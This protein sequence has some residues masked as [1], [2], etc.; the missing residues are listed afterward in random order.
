MFRPI[1]Q[2]ENLSKTVVNQIL[3]AINTGKLKPGDKLPSERKMVEIFNVSRTVIRDALK[4]LVGLGMIT[5]HHGIGTFVN[6]VDNQEG[7]CLLTSL[8]EIS[9]GTSEELLQVRE[10]L[11]SNAVVWCTYNATNEDVRQLGMIVEKSKKEV[12]ESK[13]ALF[14]AEFHLKIADAAGNSVLKRLMVNLMDLLGEN[15]L[16]A[17]RVPGRQHHSVAEHVQILDAI[18]ARNSDLARLYMLHHLENV[19]KEIRGANFAPK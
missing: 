18:K 4:T 1:K 15:R 12:D 14:D 17:L 13:L 3:E 9:K 7:F 8:L 11:E 10:I 5:I 2:D 16:R 6:E 19:K